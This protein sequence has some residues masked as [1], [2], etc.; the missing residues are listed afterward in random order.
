VPLS[1]AE[2]IVAALAARGIPHVLKVYED[3]GHGL[4]KRVN[5]QDAYPAAIG[6]LTAQLGTV[7]AR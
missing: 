2:Q 4:A 3:E 6:F 7:A 5:R 1:E